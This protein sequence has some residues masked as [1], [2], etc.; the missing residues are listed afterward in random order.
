MKGPYRQSTKRATAKPTK[1]V[2]KKKYPK[3]TFQI[4]AFVSGLPGCF[5]P[6]NMTLEPFKATQKEALKKLEWFHKKYYQ[7][8]YDLGKCIGYSLYEIRISKTAFLI[9]KF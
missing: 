6:V 4:C 8:P 3:K 1:G 2:Q 7:K 5:N 9:K